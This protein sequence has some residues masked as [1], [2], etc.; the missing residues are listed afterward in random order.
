MAG[1]NVSGVALG[2]AAAGGVL[3]WSGVQNRRVTDSLRSLVAGKTP[4]GA[5]G[6]GGATGPSPASPPTAPPNTG[7]GNPAANKAL[8]QLLAGPYGWA[9]GAQWQALDALEMSEASYDNTVWNRAGSGAYGIAQALPATKYPPAGQPPPVGT[10]SASAQ[11]TW[12]LGYIHDRYGDPVS[13]W[14]FHQANNWY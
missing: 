8:M 1:G 7:G 4:T 14:A 11:I 5:P 12:M 2:T 3:L 6:P 10:S 9:T 13:A